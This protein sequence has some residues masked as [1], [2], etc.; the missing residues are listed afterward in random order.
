[1]LTQRF[2]DQLRTLHDFEGFGHRFR[3]AGDTGSLAL[4][5]CQLVNVVD[6]FGWQLVAIFDAGEA[7]RQD[8]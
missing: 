2:C 8:D 5:R 3:K 1:M 6:D 7:R 4:G